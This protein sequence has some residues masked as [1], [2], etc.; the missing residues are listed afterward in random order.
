[1]LVGD[2]GGGGGG[3]GFE[4]P[5]HAATSLTRKALATSSRTRDDAAGKL[6]TEAIAASCYSSLSLATTCVVGN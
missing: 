1:M 3:V 2:G 5:P 4:Q 6:A